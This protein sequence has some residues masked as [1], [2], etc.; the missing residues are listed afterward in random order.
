MAS[1]VD[2]CNIA[3]AHVG[4]DNVISSIDPPDGSTEAGYCK[5]FYPIARK[6]LI[7]RFVWPFATKR[8]QLAVVTNDSLIWSY[9]YAVPAD[10]IR[11]VRVLRAQL[12]DA[13]LFEVANGNATYSQLFDEN[14]SVPF[15]I[16]DGVLRTHEPDAVLL[17]LRDVIDTT[18]YTPLFVS[19]LGYLLAAYL[20]GP[21]VRG[22]E[23]ANAAQKYRQLALAQGDSAMT[24]AARASRE[25]HFPVA[26]HLAAR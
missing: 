22:S 21:M 24:F 14:A 18:K 2:I 10:S 3:L 12:V 8:Q 15:E 1:T 4:S 9:A 6:E 20:A 5:R 13:L 19:A 7:E 16:E 11:P 26:T 17:Y 25:Q 23:G